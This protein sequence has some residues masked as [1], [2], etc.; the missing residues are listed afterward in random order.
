MDQQI[1]NPQGSVH[2][3]VFLGKMGNWWRT[4][5]FKK[6]SFNRFL[7]YSLLMACLLSGTALLNS[8]QIILLTFNSFWNNLPLMLPILTVLLSIML[9]PYDLTKLDGWLNLCNY[10]ALGL[11][12]FAIW[13]FVAGQSVEQYIRINTEDVFNK[14]HSLL[15]VYGSFIWAGFCSVISAMASIDD[16]M[17]RRKWRIIQ[18]FLVSISLTFLGMPYFLFE[19]KID[20]EKRLGFSFDEKQFIVSIPF[21]DPALN[22]HL[23]RSTNP[24]I[25]CQ[26]YRGVAAKTS[27]EAQEKATLIFNEA[28]DSIQFASSSKISDESSRRRVE[29]LENLIVAAPEK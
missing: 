1:T 3:N 2:K 18:V 23:G 6:P 14:E 19:K 25:Q 9:R 16:E 21:R 5:D 26:I 27:Q 29:I 8:G 17:K 15:L 22:Q 28:E 12:S 11:V 7:G 13:A 4:T 20:V 10:L 24:L